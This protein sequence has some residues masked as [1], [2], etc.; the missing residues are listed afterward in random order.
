MVD[1]KD[2]TGVGRRQFIRSI[3]GLGTVAESE[4][5]ATPSETK[6]ISGKFFWTDLRTGQVGFPSGHAVPSGCPGSVMKIISAAALTEAHLLP[7]DHKY[8]CR[9]VIKIKNQKFTCLAPHGNV[10]LVHALGLSC[11]CF[12][13]QA[14]HLLS[15]SL[16]LDFA[17]RFGLDQQVASFPSGKFPEKAQSSNIENY[18]LGLADDLQPSALQILR[19]AAIVATNGNV[20]YMHSAEAPDPTASRFQLKLS[21]RTWH[22][23]QQGMQISARQGTGKKLDPDNKMHIAI[24]TGTV[25]HGKSFQ[26]WICGYFPWDAPK[27]AFVLRSFSGT[28]QEEAVPQARSFLFANEWP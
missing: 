27:Y 20:P 25:P 16:L 22:V 3:F 6:E 12:F 23:L 28:S 24:K 14:A 10:D 2:K 1:K 8:E 11:N 21:E 15:P 19:I 5:E 7:A 13:A 18:V 9:G 4:V 17:K 26:S